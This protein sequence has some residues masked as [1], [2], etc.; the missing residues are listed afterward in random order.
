[1]LRQVP[2]ERSRR[3]LI[4]GAFGV[5]CVVVAAAVVIAVSGHSAT[6]T[7]VSGGHIAVSAG[8]DDCGHGWNT[9]RGGPITFAVSNSTVGSEDVYVTDSRTSAVYGEIEG[10]ATNG[11]RS[12][13]VV[14]G[15]GSYRFVCI[16]AESDPVFGHTVTIS[17][18][19]AIAGVTPAI[20]LVTRAELLPA[21]KQYQA[22]IAS[23][24]PALDADVRALDSAVVSGDLGAARRAWLTGHL[25]YESLGA[26]YGAFGDA[27]SAINGSPASGTTA[28]D[29]PDLTGFHKVEAMLWGGATGAQIAP[30]T[31]R[32]VADVDTLES[33]FATIRINA[34]DVGLRA[35]EII[36]NAIQFE[37]PAVTDAG[38]HTNL[39]TIGANIVGTRQALAPL[40]SILTSRYPD[41]AET[42]QYLD[43]SAA[44]IASYQQPDGSWTP[45]DNL[46]HD[47]RATLDSTLDQTVELLAP[48]AA[49]CD[50]RASAE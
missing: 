23:R 43:R 19:G 44:L 22:W 5:L 7:E 10:L 4:V 2:G 47:E 32:L 30:V 37:L 8:I 40:E 39:A 41:L 50:P 15:D 14:L 33:N 11:L 16:P 9:S 42:E 28:L 29:D 1:M 38:S 6:D 35:H 25:E 18:A 20:Q 3:R 48:I 26:A 34:L 27:D 36:E 31:A 13:T 12:L 49:I 17:A 46:T 45:I 21:A 24:L